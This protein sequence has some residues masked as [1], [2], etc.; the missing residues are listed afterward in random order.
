M[1]QEEQAG[2]DGARHDAHDGSFRAADIDESRRYAEFHTIDWIQDAT[3]EFKRKERRLGEGGRGGGRGRINRVRDSLQDAHEAGQAWI[4]VTLAGTLIGVN[5]AVLSILTEYL[6]DLKSGYCSGGWYLNRQFC[7][8]GELEEHCADWRP[9]SRY[10]I[11]NYLFF[12]AFAAVFSGTA[13][14]AVRHYAPYAAGSGISEIKCIIGG[15]VMRGFLDLKTLLIKSIGL[16]LAIASGLSV[17]KEG[18]SVHVAVCAG[19]VVGRLFDRYTRHAAKMR[20]IYIA[21][22]AAGVAVAF[23]SP[24]GGV[25]FA[26]EEMSSSYHLRTMWRSYFCALV[27]TSVLAAID[28]FRTGQLVMFEVTYDRSWH[29]FEI[30]FF[31]ALGV[32]G[33]LY[34]EFVMRWNMAVAAF[35]RKHLG[36]YGLQEAVILAVLTAAV[37]FWNPFLQLDMTK[38][39]GLLFR[40]CEGE[41]YAGLCSGKGWLVLSLLFATAVRTLLVIVSYGC[42]VPA[43]IFVPSMAIGATFGRAVGTLVAAMHERHPHWAIF[44]SCK[45][46]VPCITPGTYAFLGAAASLSGI[47]HITISVVVI[48]FE[49]TG[50][51]TFILPTMIVVGVTKVVSEYV[52]DSAGIADRMIHFN[53]F[54]CLD[55]KED[56]IFGIEVGAIMVEDPIA[57]E[58]S[59]TIRALEDVLKHPYQSFPVVEGDKSVLGHIGRAELASALRSTRASHNVDDDTP[60]SL[61]NTAHGRVVDISQ[62]VDVSP[63]IVHPAMPLETVV[64]LFKSLGPRVILVASEGRLKGLLTVKDILKF[65][66]HH[67]HE[68][69]Q[70]TANLESPTRTSTESLER[71]ALASFEAVRSWT[72]TNVSRYATTV[73]GAFDRPQ[74]HR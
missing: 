47:M 25:L 13:A 56:P 34:G 62:W 24:I 30:L 37:A 64:D 61:S 14:Y 72:R 41:D 49:L 33:G 8:W 68:H 74:G 43:G 28:P 31:A 3:V 21:T 67:E 48:M 1:S 29:F 50:A 17:G 55:N 59:T 44:A 16:P 36:A 73:R 70:H 57:L 53:G 45:P 32:F 66:H 12:V 46:D 20:E 51:L 40:E 5:A 71:A 27:A 42:K 22:S 15:F 18:P 10:S 11:F 19:D 39:M 26:L 63:L 52:G 9:W 4:A 6:G 54:P 58:D 23:G 2:A 65:G 60:C 7:C 38:A 69:R 35:R